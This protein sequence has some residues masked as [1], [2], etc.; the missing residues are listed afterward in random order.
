MG[1]NLNTAVVAGIVCL[2]VGGLLGFA[3]H[4]APEGPT[5]DDVEQIVAENVPTA[6]EIAA[7]VEVPIVDTEKL[8]QIEVKLDE[9]D[10]EVREEDIKDDKAE[11]LAKEELDTKS[12]KKDLMNVLNDEVCKEA[13]NT[14]L[15]YVDLVEDY[16]DIYEIKVRDVTIT[17]NGDDRTVELEIKAYFYIDGD[18]DDEG[19][20]LAEATFEIDLEDEDDEDVSDAEIEITRIYNS[21]DLE[22][23]CEVKVIA[24]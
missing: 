18:D 10:K 22:D 7:L 2:I 13:C 9:I 5:L 11:E 8:T 12:F 6:D 14:N 24:M 23:F 20:V 17:G 16:K 15:D 19:K 1:E 3:V 4:T 21:D